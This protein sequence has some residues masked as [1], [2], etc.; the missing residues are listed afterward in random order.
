MARNGS[1]AEYIDAACASLHNARTAN[2]LRLVQ[3]VSIASAAAWIE[4]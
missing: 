4:H 2:E 3:A 1:E